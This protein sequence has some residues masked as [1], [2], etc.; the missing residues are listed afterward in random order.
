MFI[1]Y[2]RSRRLTVKRKALMISC[3]TLAVA[4][5]ALAPQ[6]ARA[7]A[8]NGT[9]TGSTNVSVPSLSTNTIVVTDQT[10]T[11]NWTAT[12]NDF[13][14]AANTATFTSS[15]GITDYTILNR[16]T[17]AD[18]LNPIQLNG[19][20]IATLEGTSTIGGNV[21]FYSPSGI[22]VG[23]DANFDVG[24]LLLTSIN[25]TL[26]SND[27]SGFSAT[28]APATGDGGTIQVVNGAQINA[29]Q[30]QNSYVAIVAPRIEQGG[31]V[32][33]NG[34]AAYVAAESLTMTMNQGL[35]DILVNVNGGTTDANG[36]VHSGTT[37]GAASENATDYHRIYMVA[38]PKNQAMTML[39]GGNV[40]FQPATVAG[41]EN[42]MI[43]LGSGWNIDDTP[44]GINGIGSINTQAGIS[45]GTGNYTSDVQ[46][47]STGDIYASADTGNIV[48]GGDVSLRSLSAGATGNVTLGATNGNILSVAGNAY[49]FT[50]DALYSSGVTVGADSG[51]ILTIAGAATFAAQDAVDATPGY[52]DLY[53]YNGG[54]VTVTGQTQIYANAA[55]ASPDVETPSTDNYAG[56]VDIDAWGTGSTITLGAVTIDASADG[57]D[58]IGNGDGTAG[59]AYGG[60]IRVDASSGGAITMASLYASVDGRGGD[61]QDAGNAGGAGYGGDFTIAVGDGSVSITGDM[62][63]SALGIGGSYTG[64]GTPTIAAGGIGDGGLVQAYVYEEGGSFSVGGVSTLR[65]DATGGSGVDGGDA[66]GGGAG[67]SAFA[68]TLELGTSTTMTATATGGDASSGFGGSGGDAEGGVGWVEARANPFTEGFV[69]PPG[70]ITGGTVSI[71]S[72]AFG[73]DGGASDGVEI[74][75]GSGGTGSGG[76]YTG[77]LGSGGSFAASADGGSITLGN[78]ALLAMGTGGAGGDGAGSFAGGAGGEA[79]GGSASIGN[80]GPIGTPSDATYGSVS[81]DVS[82]IGGAGGT[83][84]AGQGDGGDATA[85]GNVYVAEDGR[86]WGGAFIDTVGNV[87]INGNVSM[88][89]TATGGAGATGGDALGGIVQAAAWYDTASNLDIIGDLSLWA[90]ANGGLGAL[91]GGGAS[92]G[93]AGMGAL[94]GATFDVSGAVTLSG[95]AEAGSGSVAGGSGYGGTIEILADGGTVATGAVSGNAVGIGGAGGVGGTGSGGTSYVTVDG[96]GALTTGEIGIIARGLGG[97]GGTGA[98][99]GI[100]GAGTGGDIL[101]HV[102]TGSMTSDVISLNARGVGGAGGIGSSGFGGDGGM[103][104]GGSISLIVDAAGSLDAFSFSGVTSAVG[105]SGGTGSAGLGDGGAAQ[106]GDNEVQIYGSAEFQG[107]TTAFTG[108]LVTAFAEGGSGLTGGNAVS[109]SSTIDVYG[110]LTT[111][112]WLQAS[113]GAQGGNGSDYGGDASGGTATISVEGSLGAG[114]IHIRTSATGGIGALAG[115]DGLAGNSS[116]FNSGAVTAGSLEVL[117]EGLGGDSSAGTGGLGDA[118]FALLESWGALTAT[119]EVF[120]S[121]DGEGGDGASAGGDGYG[122][123]AAVR[124]A[125]GTATLSGS[126]SVTATGTGG[127]SANGDGGDGIGGY[128]RLST[129]GG[130]VAT[131]NNLTVDSSATGG[132]GLNGGD[133]YAQPSVEGWGG[134]VVQTIDAGSSLT[135]TGQTNVVSNGVGGAATGSEGIGGDGSGGYASLG[136]H[137]G[138]TMN[139]GNALIAANGSGGTG[140]GVGEGTGGT[141]RLIASAGTLSASDVT[142]RADGSSDG[143]TANIL[144]L[145]GGSLTVQSIDAQAN[146]SLTG[147]TILVYV[148][149]TSMADLGMA[150]LAAIGSTGGDITIDIGAATSSS[151][152]EGVAGEVLFADNLTLTSSGT[153]N[154]L[155][156]NGASI[157]VASVMTA[158]AGGLITLED[159]GGNAFITAN[160]VT[161]DGSSVLFN[162]DFDAGNVALIVDGNYTLAGLPTAADNFSVEAGGSITAGDLTM[163]GSLDLDAGINITLGNVTVGGNLDLDAGG[164]IGF[165][166]FDVGSLDFDAGGTVTGGNIFADTTATGSAQGAIS[167]QD[168][169]VGPGPEPVDD[170]SVGF[171]S[172]T[173]VSVGN[174]VSYGRVGFATTGNLTTGTIQAGSLV[175]AMVG[176][177]ITTGAITTAAT[178]TVFFADDSMYLAA[179]G[180]ADDFN[181]DLVLAATPV[182][183]GGSIA[184]NGAVN[185]GAFEAYAGTTLT[186]LDLV[187][188]SA[189]TAQSGGN[190]QMGNASA[191][192]IISLNSGGSINA[193]SLDA[194]TVSLAV[195]GDFTTGDL[196]V[197]DSLLVSA[198][199]NLTA[200]N[201]IAGGS[202]GLTA[203]QNLQAGNL[204]AGG[205]LTLN[206]GGSIVAGN[207]TAGEGIAAEAGTTLSLGSVTTG[208]A[209]PPPPT[210][211]VSTAVAASGDDVVLNSAGDMNVGSIDSQGAITLTSGGGM[212]TGALDA[213]TNIGA[214]S[215]GDMHIESASAGQT[216]SLTAANL[217]TGDL[218]GQTVTTD[219]SGNSTVGSVDAGTSAAF[220]AGGLAS[221]NG[222]VAAPTI[223]VTSGD[224]NIADGGAL[225]LFGTTNLLTFNAVTDG[226]VIIGGEEGSSTSGA[227]TLAEA[228]GIHSAAVVFNAGASNV[229]VRDVEIEGSQTSGGGVSAV[230][231]NTSGSVFVEGALQYVN[232]G[233]GDT[234]AINAGEMIQVITDTGSI[235]MTSS[236]GNLAGTLELTADNIWVAEAAIIDQL[237]SNPDFAGRDEALATSGT[238]DPD[239]SVGAGAIEA[240]VGDSLLVQNSNTATQPA[241]V[242]VG[243]GGMTVNNTGSDPA[244]VVI[245]GR[246]TSSDGSVT[247][248]PAFVEDVDFE[249][250]GGYSGDSTVNGCAVGSGCAPEEA[251]P[252]GSESILGPVGM[253]SSDPGGAP[254]DDGGSGSEDEGEEE[255]EGGEDGDTSVD[256]SAYLIN[257]GPLQ[258]DTTVDEP[259]TSGSDG[260]GGSM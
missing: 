133:G 107:V 253:A 109:G 130:G 165:T 95:R 252:G 113:A 62:F 227:Y 202:L 141:I 39:L 49:L 164:N 112:G 181:P 190:L 143:G 223:A 229:T 76:L 33:V 101:F 119:G 209:P 135:L 235:S 38:V 128:A 242:A 108:F 232:A 159:N 210:A 77:E 163:G 92:G 80:Y 64:E 78:V 219:A 201:I 31:N 41:V 52:V 4:T 42:G 214:T 260:P 55:A 153:I 228:G 238:A 117:A 129:Y 239:G 99:G 233:T 47:Y 63:L 24:G 178:G 7:Q 97:T 43:V 30:Q 175:M 81:M 132:T 118:G 171:E 74:A 11:I 68:G 56:D 110:L 136:V 122:S 98:T 73:G 220:T 182:A 148:D 16:V 147:G 46:A 145:Y 6:K 102:G 241:G 161:L 85:G 51:G 121:S 198:G 60:E 231:L 251:V 18:S 84:G 44:A 204:T 35:F 179:G 203:G 185:T 166:S 93:Y 213:V 90:W 12:S 151:S 13:L 189:I 187:A 221:F 244:T 26:I 155:S 139:A 94:A 67:F 72:S 5:A 54:Q 27:A 149:P 83:G 131:V 234:L 23:A 194:P 115:G 193:T 137:T 79:F 8:F 167:L 197:D 61:M 120:V 114:A 186:T 170:F 58:N 176:G 146:G 249:G 138:S 89:A 19:N 188:G 243:D 124:L 88:S 237:E 40:G 157:D 200:T 14:P 144:S 57:M 168:I 105:G 37:G 50:T 248:G 256:P 191:G 169:I 215:I 65:A 82:A 106:G 206:A 126:V 216:L 217:I 59:D 17:P 177:D 174:I 9:A 29:T 222:V 142:M 71:D 140:A 154:L 21:W 66:F 103:G 225:G 123:N 25:P 53:A 255:D 208:A 100:G 32:Q 20:V 250:T 2:P 150:S 218:S 1:A 111:T 245:Y 172:A 192:S 28:F 22:V 212:T 116:L 183:T 254:A 48:F 36:I 125:G 211:L 246:Q 184:I 127:T 160:A 134:S 158:I 75:A 230:T 69:P 205:S 152:F 87:T 86:D 226:G 96:G 199:G 224:I 173:S 3:A 45:I 70:T 34:S 91:T 247:E 257:S 195:A 258:L 15:G 196:N 207:L 156:E 259:I 162:W 236:S 240:N 180:D 10:A 104:T